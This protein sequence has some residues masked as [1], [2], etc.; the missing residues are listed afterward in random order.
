M[1]RLC[2]FHFFSSVIGSFSYRRQ[3][4]GQNQRHDSIT[5]LSGA[6]ILWHIANNAIKQFLFDRSSDVKY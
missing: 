4:V 2:R 1:N 6:S 5:A 3:I